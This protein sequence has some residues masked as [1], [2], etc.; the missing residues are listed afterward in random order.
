MLKLIT[1]GAAL[2]KRIDGI[3]T[4]GA[5]LDKEIHVVAVSSLDHLANHGD[6]GYINRLYFAL[7]KGARKAAFTSWALTYGSVVANEDKATKAEK[8]FVY[9]KDK[10][11]DV[12]GSVADP[13]YD[14]KPDA[15]PDMVLDLQ[16]AIESIIKR[17][18][19]DG[20]QLVHGEKLAA[21]Q[22]LVA[23]PEPETEGEEA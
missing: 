16:K 10:A 5:K 11:T 21:L 7:P 14:H 1:D 13:W 15:S 22:A 19:K 2:V 18:K 6:V 20:M 17:A 8:P 3:K 9:S 23:E 12:A 4:S